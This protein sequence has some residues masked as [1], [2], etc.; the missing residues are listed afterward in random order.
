MSILLKMFFSLCY[1]NNPRLRGWMALQPKAFP[2]PF[3]FSQNAPNQSQWWKKNKHWNYFG[4]A[5]YHSIFVVW[6]KLLFHICI[7]RSTKICCTC[8]QHPAGGDRVADMFLCHSR[9]PSERP[10]L[11]LLDQEMLLL[12]NIQLDS[13]TCKVTF[14]MDVNLNTVFQFELVLK[15]E[16]YSRKFWV[17]LLRTYTHNTPHAT[18]I[19]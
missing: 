14:I 13:Y 18:G 7:L 1:I 9:F 10:L 19:L 12:F 5:Y 11:W 8:I 4:V 6:P 17:K 16:Q 2:M 15:I 3:L